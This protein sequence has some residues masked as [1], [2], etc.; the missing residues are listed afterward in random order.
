MTSSVRLWRHT[1]CKRVAELKLQCVDFTSHLYVPEVDPV[2]GLVHHDRADHNHF[3]KRI[4]QNLTIGGYSAVQY[5]SFSDV[6]ADPLSGLTHAALV[7]KRKQSV[8]D[9]ERL[10]SYHVVNSLERQRYHS[11]EATRC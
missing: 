5:E 2:T 9:A 1:F 4:A 6:L 11:A 7:G 8:K 10:L 3:L